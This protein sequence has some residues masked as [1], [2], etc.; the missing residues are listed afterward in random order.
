MNQRLFIER[1]EAVKNIRYGLAHWPV[2]ALLGPR[3]CGKSFLVRGFETQ[4]ENFFDLHSRLDRAR[5]EE[6]HF[7]V[8]DG[9]EGTV[10]LDEA[11]DNPE[12]FPKLRILADRRNRSTRFLITGSASPSLYR[13]VSES[14]AGRVRQ[15]QL[16]GFILDEVGSQNWERLWNQGGFPLSYLYDREQLSMDWRLGYID[17][18]LGRDLPAL[19]DSKLS[20]VQLRRLLQ[21]IATSHGQFWNHSSIGQQ[22]GVNYKTIQRYIDIFLGAY[23]LRELPPYHT[24][25]NKRLRKASKLYVRDSGLLHALLFIPNY[26]AL[27]GHPSFGFSWEGFGIEQV[28][29]LTGAREGE[30]FTWSLQNGPEVDLVLQR[31]QGVFGFEFKAGDGPTLTKSMVTA[32]KDLKLAKLFVIYPGRFNY[33]IADRVEAVGVENLPASLIKMGLKEER[34]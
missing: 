32:I 1:T 9:L 6:S 24:N 18:F 13:N 30:Y 19:A 20:S 29:N 5:L 28:I 11:Q 16:N 21:Y 22:I 2:T 27:A 31:S 12:L 15:V 14:L 8:L 10:I 26:Q 23:I 34:G 33:Q 7:Q 3:Q 4:P 25:L 17:Q